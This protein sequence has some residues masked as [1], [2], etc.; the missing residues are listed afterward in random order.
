MASSSACWRQSA[1]TPPF[2]PQRG[3]LGQH[4]A[5][6]E[7]MHADDRRCLGFVA[8]AVVE[9][10]ALVLGQRRAAIR[11]ACGP[12]EEAPSMLRAAS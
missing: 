2:K 5:I 3:F 8:L 7:E 6:P 10:R 4:V 1:A 11:Q 9:T 12:E